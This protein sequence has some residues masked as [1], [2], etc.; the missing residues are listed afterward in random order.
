MESYVSLDRFHQI[1]NKYEDPRI[2]HY[3]LMS[4][5]IPTVILTAIYL[6]SVKVTLPGYMKDR[7]PFQLKKFVIFYNFIQV[8]YSTWL[9]YG[10]L[11]G[12]WLGSKYNLEC[13]KPRA[14]KNIIFVAYMYYLSK[15]TEF[16]DTIL[17]VLRKKDNQ[18]T[19]LHLYHHCIMPIGSWIAVKYVPD[20]TM[21]FLG[22]IN[23]FIHIIMYTYYMLSAIGPEMQKYL[24]W[25]KY[26]T[27][28]QLV[29]FVLCLMNNVH[30]ALFGC[31]PIAISWWNISQSTLFFLMFFDFYK[32]AYNK[33]S[34]KITTN[35]ITKNTDLKNN[36]INDKLHEK[37]Q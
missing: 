31:L 6:I 32:Q 27:V 10:F 4:S 5:P 30:A 19:N 9:F 23:S 33:K 35:G 22:L 26:V 15:F 8:L 28:L 21:T 14:D 12:G 24:W 7:K 1:I 20:S 13:F 16:M 37:L 2:R 36:C 25:K 34:S 11:T 17:F 29:Q 18:V 3:F